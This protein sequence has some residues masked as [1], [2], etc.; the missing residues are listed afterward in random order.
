MRT[1]LRAQCIHFLQ[2]D[3]TQLRCMQVVQGFLSSN[4]DELALGQ[5]AFEPAGRR[6]LLAS[7]NKAVGQD[8]SR[9]SPRAR[10]LQQQAS[11]RYS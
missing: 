6:K 11:Q 4:A 10:L 1:S 8:F 7:E 9:L 5:D 2:Q 3:A